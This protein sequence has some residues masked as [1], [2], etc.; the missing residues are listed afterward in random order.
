MLQ[1]GLFDGTKMMMK[2]VLL[3]HCLQYGIIVPHFPLKPRMHSL[4]L[5][6]YQ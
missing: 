3:T 1:I 5:E 4:K 2:I 6:D